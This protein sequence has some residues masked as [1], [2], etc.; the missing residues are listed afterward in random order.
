[1]NRSEFEA[2][3]A[4]D[5][6]G[7]YRPWIV[8]GG[9]GGSGHM[10]SNGGGG[11]CPGSGAVGPWQF[12]EVDRAHQGDN[13][14]LVRGYMPHDMIESLNFGKAMYGE[15]NWGK[16]REIEIKQPPMYGFGELSKEARAVWG[17]CLFEAATRKNHIVEF[18]HDEAATGFIPKKDLRLLLC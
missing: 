8:A 11:G 6:H 7:A 14:Y 1:M 4:E 12:I 10:P 16:T 2:R 13:R 15:C 5:R 3:C 17:K 18:F 9:G